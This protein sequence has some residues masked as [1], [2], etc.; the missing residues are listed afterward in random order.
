MK[1]ES[2]GYQKNDGT[3]ASCNLC[4]A[5]LPHAKAPETERG[6]TSRRAAAT[7]KMPAVSP[8]SGRAKPPEVAAPPPPAPARA[9][10]PAGHRLERMGS[11]PVE[12]SPGTP[13]TIGR[14]PTCGLQVQSPRV[15]RLHA[16]ITWRGDTPVITDRGSAN[17]TIVSGAPVKEHALRDGDEIS[18]GPFVCVYRHGAT[19]LPGGGAD[20]SADMGSVT[21]PEGM[22]SGALGEGRLAEVMQSLELN[23]RTGTLSVH[24]KELGGWLTLHAGAPGAAEAGDLRDV[25]A[26]LRLLALEHGR[27]FFSSDVRTAE[28]RIRGSLSALLLE[29]ARRVDE[30]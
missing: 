15:S 7:L 25:E 24:S 29:W 13:L 26:V 9:A 18:I 28:R 16:E 1:C 6:T 20:T 3:T 22:L 23:G 10:D 30:R 2:C 5:L 21:R 12:L 17:G 4:G 14:E 19:A 27:Y 11:S 8:P